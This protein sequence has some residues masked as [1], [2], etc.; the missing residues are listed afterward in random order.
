MSLPQ[1]KIP[2]GPDDYLAWEQEQPC[3]NEYIDGEVFA[4]SGASD[5]HGTAAL[6]LAAL[7]RG[8]LRGT[9]CK[10][11]IAD[12]KVRVEAANS[13]FYPDIVVTCDPRDRTPEASHVKQYPALIVE[14]LSPSTEA[15]DRGNKFATYRQLESLQEYVLVSLE[16]RRIEVFRRDASGHW[17][18]HP[19]ALN[20]ALE[21]SSINFRCPAAEVFD[22]V[23]GE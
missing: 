6:N 10:P 19:F 16:A 12:M 15:Y 9:P 3:R 11:F 23:E 1:E 14:V 7:L 5:A 13:F 17:V 8:A 18:L 4:M 22:G 2:F 21:L 20:E